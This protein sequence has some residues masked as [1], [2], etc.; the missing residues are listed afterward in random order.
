[1]A[2]NSTYELVT[3]PLTGLASD[4]VYC[5]QLT[6]SNAG[7]SASDLVDFQQI[8]PP[9]VSVD[10]IVSAQGTT[11]TID[12]TIVPRP[13][14]TYQVLVRTRR[15][16][17]VPERPPRRSGAQDAQSDS[18][19]RLARLEYAESVSVELSG[20]T[21]GARYCV[22]F[23]GPMLHYPDTNSPL[24]RHRHSSSRPAGP[25]RSTPAR[26]P[27]PAA[28]GRCSWRMRS[29]RADGLPGSRN[30]L[31]AAPIQRRSSRRM[32]AR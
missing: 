23:V 22:L 28:R 29:R 12:A 24:A 17:L 27:P 10:K 11:A 25:L 26:P 21:R 2:I 19:D 31:L 14:A 15:L 16:G 7:G 32:Q 13:A 1:M 5:A 18:A 9:S 6:A 20:L 3:V 30:C 4:A 8:A